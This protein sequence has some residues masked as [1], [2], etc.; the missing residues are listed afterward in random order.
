MSE[1]GA[2]TRPL[3]DDEGRL[4]LIDNFYPPAHAAEL[5]ATLLAELD[6]REE[7]I[8]VYGRRVAV[9]RLVCWYGDRGAVYTYSGVRHEPLPWTATLQDVR[10]AVQVRTGWAFNSVLGNLYR[11]GNDAMGWHADKERELG[12]EPRIAALSLGATRVF[13]LRHNK[14]REVISVPLEA[15]GLLLMS[16]RLQHCWRHAVPKTRR[17]VGPRINLTFRCILPSAGRQDGL[18]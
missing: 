2:V 13:K 11:D 3:I 8:T 10:A 6:W 16:G 7:S 5:F 18:S 4:D 14:R 1:V 9:P 15:S 17:R 12:A